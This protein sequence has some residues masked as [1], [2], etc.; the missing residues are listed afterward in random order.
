MKRSKREDNTN[1][2]FYRFIDII[3]IKGGEPR[4]DAYM[5]R[6]V[7]S[8]Y[9]KKMFGDEYKRIVIEPL[10]EQNVIR[11]ASDKYGVGKFCKKY[12]LTSEGYKFFL[13]LKKEEK[14]MEAKQAKKKINNGLNKIFNESIDYKVYSDK[15][16]R[17]HSPW[18]VVPKDWRHNHILP[19]GDKLVLD[20]DIACAYPSMVKEY[21][22]NNNILH[23]S[24]FFNIEDIYTHLIETSETDMTR[25]EMKRVFNAILNSS[26]KNLKT[27]RG[28]YKKTYNTFKTEFP[29]IAEMILNINDSESY[30]GGILARNYEKPIISNLLTSISAKLSNHQLMPIFDG[31]EVWGNKLTDD[32]KYII[33]ETIEKELKK[34]KYIEMELKTI[35]E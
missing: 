5:G 29:S 15:D 34:Y 19:N 16:N 8:Q 35:H 24:G 20:I 3:F 1:Y 28:K 12:R 14:F 33:E 30:M 13:N 32:D 18:T 2:N 4:W 23:C 25:D 21:I 7:Y 10:I 17:I 9:I 6:D 22:V 27:F 26:S 11:L 31:I